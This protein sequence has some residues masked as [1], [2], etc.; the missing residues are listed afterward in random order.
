M[1]VKDKIQLLIPFTPLIAVF[2]VLILR[3]YFLFPVGG[4]TDFHLARAQ[5][6]IQNPFWG[7]FWDNITYYPMGRPV[8]HQPL[9]N[10]VYAG[11][12]YLAGVRFAHSFL[13]ISQ[14]LLTVGVASWFANR[15][16]GIFA[17]YF[18]GLFSLAMPAPSTLTAAIPAAYIPI[19]AVLTIYYIPQD[20]KK[21][22]LASLVGLWTHMVALFCFIPLYLVDNYRDKTNL[23][24]I[25]LL[26][27][28]WL[29]W[30]V[31]W[32]YFKDR[33][34]TGGI[35]YTLTHL[36]LVPPHP[37]S[38]AFLIFLAVFVLGIIGLYLLYNSNYRQFKLFTTYIVIVIFFSFFGFNGDFLRGFQFAALPMAILAGFAVERGYKNLSSNRNRLL[39]SLF[40]LLMVFI[41]MMG[42]VIFFSYLPN[43]HGKGWDALETPFEGEYAPLKDYIENST[44]ANQVVWTER[45]LSEKV[46]WMTGRSV[47]NGLYSDNTY[48]GTRG[49]V[50]KHQ[51]I[52]IYKSDGYVTVRDL[53]NNTIAQIKLGTY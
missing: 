41:S 38:Y 23:K 48:G 9:F 32:V 44:S 20:K 8:W 47:S 45:E 11:L 43:Q 42:V 6:I 4:D 31:Y 52:N 2:I 1:Q 25:A 13:C 33:L 51:N 12:W 35:F 16:Y 10:A 34:V 5:E 21:A 28:S 14:V 50:D 46:A 19:L 29:F 7:L 17:G 26:L 49:F 15:E 36:K 22:F 39:S 24:I 40:L 3:P 37:G 18:A 30:A 53:N 27:P